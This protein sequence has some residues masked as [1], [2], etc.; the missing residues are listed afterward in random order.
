MKVIKYFL[1]GALMLSISAQSM[2]QDSN[3]NTEVDAITKVIVDNQGNAS[4]IKDAVK[5]FTKTF[6]KNPEAL[7]GLGRAFLEVK[8]MANAL[9]YADLAIKANKNNAAGYLLKGDMAVAND[10]GGDAAMWYQT[11]TTFDSKNPLGYIKYARIYQKVDT[12]GAAN[13]LEKLRTI[14]PSYPVDA[15][16]AYMY[17]K[18][19]KLQKA[20]EYYDQIK[21][22][23]N[24][25][26][27]FISDYASSAMILGFTQKSLNAVLQGLNKSPRNAGFNRIAFYDY[28]DLKDYPNA[29]KYADALFNASDSLKVLPSDY[30]YYAFAL[31]GSGRADEAIENFLKVY[32]EDKNE[33]EVLKQVS[34]IYLEKKEH[35]KAIEYYQKY[36]ETLDKKKAS[37]YSAMAK[38]YM[39][40]AENET[41]PAAKQAA[42][43]KADQMYADL[44]TAMPNNEDY[45][46][47]NRAHVHHMMNPDV[48]KG[49]AKPYYDRYAQLVETKTEKTSAEVST[50]AEAYNYLSVYYI[51]NDQ[52]AKAKE[53]AGKLKALQPDNETAKQILAL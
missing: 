50:L 26:N 20:V 42:L 53:Y 18:N 9:K 13:M 4:A 24:L 46:V 19:G 6:K 40:L 15:E 22:L 14:D 44:A 33:T 21:N 49:A 7:A 17:S 23:G 5:Q 10:N 43:A 48:K 8:D 32:N 29:L 38:I 37:D 35:D 39:N 28:T 1:A 47:Y 30:K 27:Y 25:E 11:A 12:Q 51:Q 3:V 41:T 36:I 2:A 52:V 31:K 34:D 45:A 16:I